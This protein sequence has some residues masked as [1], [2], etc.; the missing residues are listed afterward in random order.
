V[1]KQNLRFPITSHRRR[2]QWL[3]SLRIVVRRITIS[4]QYVES[5]QNETTNQNNTGY[6]QDVKP[7]TEIFILTMFPGIHGQTLTVDR[8]QSS[9]TNSIIFTIIIIARLIVIDI[10]I[11]IR[12]HMNNDKR[13]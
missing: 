4:H 9:D 5:T 8:I 13:K 3:Q 1:L 2:V 6:N 10:D 12:V 7:R 11:D